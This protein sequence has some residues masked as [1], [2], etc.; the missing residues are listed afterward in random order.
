MSSSSSSASSSADNKIR[1]VIIGLGLCGWELLHAFKELKDKRIVVT[2]IEPRDAVFYK[3]GAPR[4]LV[5]DAYITGA[6]PFW[7][8]ASNLPAFAT[9]VRS[10]VR[11]IDKAAKCVTCD[12]G[13]SVPYDCLVIAT[14]AS[15]AAVGDVA[16]LDSKAAL[17]AAMRERQAQI[18]A[19]QSICL[20]GGG[21]VGS[22]VA[23]EIAAAF[24]SKRV[25]LV[26]AGPLIGKGNG[27]PLKD[28]P[29]DKFFAKLDQKA[30]AFGN[31]TLL[32]NDRITRPDGVAGAVDT[33]A[34]TYTS[35]QGAA[36]AADLTI[37]CVGEQITNPFRD[38]FK[39]NARGQIVVNKQLQ[40]DGEECVFALGDV[41]AKEL[42]SE[43]SRVYYAPY[44][45]ATI[46][47]NVVKV[48]AKR[49]L[50]DY[51]PPS[52]KIIFATLGPKDGAGVLNGAVVGGIITRS[53]KGGDLFLGRTK[54]RLGVK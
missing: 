54:S 3:L 5:S 25:T 38:D 53:L 21:Y 19:A 16:A 52:G 39:T 12:D 24:P 10:R 50:A 27:A 35:Q 31:V 1:V 40:V 4:A 11:A 28:E 44:W 29:S 42:V 33:A 23:Y 17:Q 47:A 30:R 36:I 51:K 32:C 34:R 45:A 41:A 15:Q 6:D 7:D 48:H 14:G 2:A 37:W 49:A 8:I 13:S 22:E 43:A 9:H 46:A 18:A 26:H 20:V